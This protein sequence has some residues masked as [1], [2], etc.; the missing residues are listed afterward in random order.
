MRPDNSSPN[1][2]PSANAS[3]QKKL[4]TESTPVSGLYAASLVKE[5]GFPPG[6]I[7]VLSD[8]GRAD[9]CLAHEDRQGL[10]HRLNPSGPCKEIIK[11]LTMDDEI[12]SLGPGG[13]EASPAYVVVL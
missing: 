11:G 7:N 10:V 6:V 5:A 13:G 8:H 9:H 1:I 4:N 12:N 2:V 3:F